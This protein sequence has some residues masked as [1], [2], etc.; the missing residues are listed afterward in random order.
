MKN[1]S[2]VLDSTHK[3][4]DDK[5]VVVYITNTE[6]CDESIGTSHPI[7]MNEEVSPPIGES[8][9]YFTYEVDF[10]FKVSVLITGTKRFLKDFP[11]EFMS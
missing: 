11:K 1:E 7:E 9:S 8:K 5:P 3:E 4:K 2:V 6:K 10:P